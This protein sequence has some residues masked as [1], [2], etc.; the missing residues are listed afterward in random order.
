[1]FIFRP[2]CFF[3]I[4]LISINANSDGS[5]EDNHQALNK[6]A[7]L[8]LTVPLNEF[9]SG[10][11]ASNRYYFN[12]C[13]SDLEWGIHT[14]KDEKGYFL[15]PDHSRPSRH[16]CKQIQSLGN[17]NVMFPTAITY[18]Q[19]EHGGYWKKEGD[20]LCYESGGAT[21]TSYCNV[22]PAK[23][24]LIFR[25]FHSAMTLLGYAITFSCTLFCCYQCFSI[26]YL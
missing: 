3:L 18:Q 19:D 10:G 6:L 12:I 7:D 14:R 25:T 9:I 1:M 2:A 13:R 21:H 16:P 17:L 4:L 15:S 26:N 22:L 11:P 5:I 20:L 8:L 24:H 23:N